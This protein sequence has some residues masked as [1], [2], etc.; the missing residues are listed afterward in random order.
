MGGVELVALSGDP[1]ILP[2]EEGYERAIRASAN[3]TVIA[4]GERLGLPGDRIWRF[5][6]PVEWPPALMREAEQLALVGAIAEQER[7]VSAILGPRNGVGDGVRAKGLAVNGGRSPLIE[8]MAT[9]FAEVQPRVE[10][11]VGDPDWVAG[12]TNG[13]LLPTRASAA[14]GER[15]CA[16][17]NRLAPGASPGD[18]R[19]V[20]ERARPHYIHGRGV[21]L[22]GLGP[23]SVDG[24]LALTAAQAVNELVVSSDCAQALLEAVGWRPRK[25]R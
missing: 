20:A 2:G 7:V 4:L 17:R 9:V 15:Q 8:L 22:L 23:G 14:A 5:S 1:S 24:I 13:H 21:V 6:L 16:L 3:R 12:R 10:G 19:R 18:L 11:G 25:A